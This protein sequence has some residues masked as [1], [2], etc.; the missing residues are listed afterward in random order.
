MEAV[1]RLSA[2]LRSTSGACACG[3]MASSGGRCPCCQDVIPHAECGDCASQVQALAGTIGTLVDDTLRFLPAL[4]DIIQR[5][6]AATE[7]KALTSVQSQIFTVERAFRRF[8]MAAAEFDRGC[9]SSHTNLVVGVAGDLL[10]ETWELERL[11]EPAAK[12]WAEL[13]RP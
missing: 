9:P 3:H 5:R 6:A 12:R 1:R 4:S 11:L 8:A 2:Q 7:S 10:R 13:G